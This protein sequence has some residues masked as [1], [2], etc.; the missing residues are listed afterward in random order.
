M[1]RI[2]VRVFYFRKNDNRNLPEPTKNLAEQTEEPIKTHS[3]TCKICLTQETIK[4]KENER[5]F[6]KLR[7]LTVLTFFPN[8]IIKKH[9][10]MLN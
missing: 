7:C 8:K 9:I 2:N 3:K 10:A 4:N 6:A 1:F 5:D